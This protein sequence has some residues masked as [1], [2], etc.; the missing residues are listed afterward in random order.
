MSGRDIYENFTNGP[1][2]LGLPPGVMT[3]RNVAANYADR[4]IVMTKLASDMEPTWQGEAAGAAQRGA[5][6]LA[7]EHQYASP[8]IMMVAKSMHHQAEAFD[9]ARNSV[10]PVPDMPE[11]PG[12]WDNVVS[13][14]QANQDYERQ[15]AAVDAANENNIRVMEA[16]ENETARNAAMLSGVPQGLNSTGPTQ[17]AGNPPPTGGTGVSPTP[18]RPPSPGGG[19]G[20]GSTASPA[21][22]SSSGTTSSETVASGWTES[23]GTTRPDSAQPQVSGLDPSRGPANQD[24]PRRQPGG[25]V[26]GPGLPLSGERPGATGGRGF[27]S[28]S[29]LGDSRG[30]GARSGSGGGARGGF[31]AGEDGM[32]GGARGGVTGRG[33]AG[34]TA[35]GRGASTRA[36]AGVPHGARGQG[37]ED[38]EHNRPSY[39]V[40]RDPEETFGTDQVTAPPVIGE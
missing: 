20:G 17:P 26:I 25:P 36:G 33:A 2:G 14:G 38:L 27:G 21:V 40:E 13:F 39:L 32:R 22:G 30:G 28:P 11:K 10:V 29:S 3:T 1:A 15:V 5:A 31:G 24:V 37:E 4:A 6:P 7:V 34:E 35:P 8:R 9:M 16:Y 19:G 18:W 23:G 12:F